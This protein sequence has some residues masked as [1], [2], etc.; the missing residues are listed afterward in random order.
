MMT[1]PG[2]GCSICTPSFCMASIV[3][4][5]SSPSRKFVMTHGPFE[6]A[7]SMIARC[8]MLLSPGTVSSAAMVEDLVTL[9][10]IELLSGC[11]AL[12]EQSAESVRITGLEGH[13]NV[14]QDF[15]QF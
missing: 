8:E 4:R 9:K 5:Q 14:L 2:S 11:A 15:R 13:A 12:G 3:E 6:S 10:C 1:E 7:P